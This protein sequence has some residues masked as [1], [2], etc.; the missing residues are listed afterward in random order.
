MATQAIRAYKNTLSATTTTLLTSIATITG[1]V[2]DYLVKQIQVSN[3]DTVA[4][5]VT[6]YG[7]SAAAVGNLIL[8]A[9]SVPANT[10]VTIDMSQLLL[11]A[12][13]IYGGADAAGVVALAITGVKVY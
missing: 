8:P 5:K 13:S 4:R 7:G 3:S 12:E 2:G 11:Q 6:L 10:V 1:S 9:V